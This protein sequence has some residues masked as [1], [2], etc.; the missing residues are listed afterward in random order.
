M[1]PSR[2][3]WGSLKT[4]RSGRIQASYV[5]PQDGVRYYAPQTY[6][7]RMDA[8]A[9][10][11]NE[12]RLI[13]METWTPPEERIK[14]KAASSITVEEYTRKWLEER[15]L[16]EGTR[17]L[18]KTHA[19]KRIYPVLGDVPVSELTP[20]LVRTWWAGM[21]KQYPTARR[22]AY[23]VLRAVMNTAVED[24]MLSE[25]P[26]RIEQKA[27]SERDVEALTPEELEIVA[28]EVHEH[29]RVAV[30]ILA[31]TSLR[32]GELIELRRKDIMDDGN[33]MLFRVRRGA[34]RVGQKIV[35][36]DTKTVRSK[37]PV[38]VPPHVA[39]MVREHMADRTKMNKGPEALLVTTTQGQRLSKSAFTR[40]LKKGYRKIGRTD[41]RVHDLR[42]VGAT[43][44]AQ[45][46]ATTKELMVRLGHTTPRMAMKYQMASEARDVEIAK[47]M[48]ELALKAR[49]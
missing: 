20:A 36:G 6:D 33:T 28:A 35:V 17:E 34:A 42:A 49:S 14:K 29:Y 12:R 16:A 4:Q 3:S 31:W 39:Q 41:L 27:P 40:S 21:G 43:Y 45:S 24:K 19:R 30:Y 2:R 10:L 38:T 26:C 44:A 18:Y 8:E 22:H 47:R 37:R 15:D 48:S 32:F 1:A 7:N 46:G 5:H 11:N 25:N 23:N 9:W 13:E